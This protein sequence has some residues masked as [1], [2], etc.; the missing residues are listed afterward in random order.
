MILIKPNSQQASN[1]IIRN[2]T[3]GDRKTNVIRAREVQYRE[4]G[5]V[6]EGGGRRTEREG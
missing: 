1:S 6:R 5:E 2:A 4:I 3:Y